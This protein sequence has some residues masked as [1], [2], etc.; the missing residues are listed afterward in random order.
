MEACSR[1]DALQEQRPPWRS[2]QLPA[3]QIHMLP[4]HHH[5]IYK[6]LEGRGFFFDSQSGFR[7]RRHTTDNLFYLSQKIKENMRNEL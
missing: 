4:Y 5:H 3:N 2:I 6:E 1:L 7:A